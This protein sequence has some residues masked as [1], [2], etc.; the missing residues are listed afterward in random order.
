MGGQPGS[1][2]VN[3]TGVFTQTGGSVGAYAVPFSG[4]VQAIAIFVGGNGY[5]RPA[6]AKRPNQNSASGLYNLQGGLIVGGCEIVGCSATGTFNQ[7]GG[8]NCFVGNGD[9]NFASSS[10]TGVDYNSEFGASCWAGQTVPGTKTSYG[11]GTYNLS[12]GLL[13]GTAPPNQGGNFV[14]EEYI[15]CSGTGTFNQ[16]GGTNICP[17]SSVSEAPAGGNIPGGGQGFYNLSAGLLSVHR[18]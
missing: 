5:I 9:S 3:G 10:I 14:G 7:S 13:T 16:T 4:K 2:V 15:G 1:N 17:G 12:G 6:S 11:Q 8:T 18:Q